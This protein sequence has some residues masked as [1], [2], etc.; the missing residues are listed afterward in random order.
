[1]TA[2]ADDAARAAAAVFNE[3]VA[4]A[5]TYAEQ[6]RAA[7]LDGFENAPF[8]EMVAMAEA[9]PKRKTT[10]IVDTGTNNS[11][12][13][14]DPFPWNP[15]P[16]AAEVRAADRASAAADGGDSDGSGGV[17]DCLAPTGTTNVLLL[18][19]SSFLRYASVAGDPREVT[20]DD[21][22]A[23]GRFWL[24]MRRYWRLLPEL[25]LYWLSIPVST[26]IVESTFSFQT[27]IDQNTR[28]R[29][30]TALHHVDALMAYLYRDVLE[31]T[32][33]R[34]LGL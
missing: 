6:S 26:T 33:K 23:P 32:I 14:A 27:L 21:R 2:D 17:P 29:R 20:A 24:R 22:R 13:F 31:G 8:A 9:L 12:A 30:S 10:N 16:S 15:R 28:R 11:G 4:P 19:W 25:M 34:T 3:F 5:R 18:E 1:M 7:H